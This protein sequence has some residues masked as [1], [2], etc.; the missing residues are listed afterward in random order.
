MI[1]NSDIA[2]LL[3]QDIKAP[4][5]RIVTTFIVLGMIALPGLL[6]S[7]FSCL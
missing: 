5:Q 6:V 3:L 4:I 7:T 2:L 1:D